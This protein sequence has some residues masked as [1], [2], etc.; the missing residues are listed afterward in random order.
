MLLLLLLLLLR[1]L[2]LLLL[3]QKSRV[4]CGALPQLHLIL[5]SM[6]FLT[7]RLFTGATLTGILGPIK[8][9]SAFEWDQH[10]IEAGQQL[11]FY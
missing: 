4:C 2:L 8:Q 10:G 3:A 6:L 7:H 9:C 5:S 1:L 11:L